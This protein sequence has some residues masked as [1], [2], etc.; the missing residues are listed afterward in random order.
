MN[1]L[2]TNF[3]RGFSLKSD[4]LRFIDSAVRLAMSDMV[5]AV[6]GGN[7]PKILWGCTKRFEVQ[8]SEIVEEGAIFFQDEIWHVYEHV[9]IGLDQGFYGWWN[10]IKEYD[11]AGTKLD[12]DLVSHQT[13]EVR[14]AI[15]SVDILLDSIGYIGESEVP[16]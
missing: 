2:D 14:K 6:I 8:G 10:F 16:R 11:A 4:D 12:A 3:N 7:G 13:Y 9:V 1:R 5:K 15:L